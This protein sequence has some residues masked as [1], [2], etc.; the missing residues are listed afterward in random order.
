MLQ[1]RILDCFVTEWTDFRDESL[2]TKHNATV[3]DLIGYVRSWSA[4]QN[5]Q[6]QEGEEKAVE[7]L[8]SLEQELV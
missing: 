2:S 4:F 6:N 5:Y 8:H 1:L 3:H 7:L